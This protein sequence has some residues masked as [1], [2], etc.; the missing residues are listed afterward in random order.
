MI[1]HLASQSTAESA[2]QRLWGAEDSPASTQPLSCPA[3][4]TVWGWTRH[5]RESGSPAGL[6]QDL[7]DDADKA[8]KFLSMLVPYTMKRGNNLPVNSLQTNYSISEHTSASRCISSGIRLGDM[9]AFCAWE[10]AEERNSYKCHFR[11]EKS[12]FSH[13]VLLAQYLFTFLCM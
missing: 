6:P 10:T 5:S 2:G 12:F 11:I 1:K 9:L 8:W 7:P 4:S 3:G 13:W